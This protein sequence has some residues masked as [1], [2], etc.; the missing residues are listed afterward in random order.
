MAFIHLNIPFELKVE[1]EDLKSEADAALKF[2][3]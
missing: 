1:A 3:L 2:V